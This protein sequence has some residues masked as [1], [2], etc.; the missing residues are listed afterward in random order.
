M[1]MYNLCQAKTENVREGLLGFIASGKSFLLIVKTV[2]KCIK[3]KKK[4]L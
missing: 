1:G 2:K 4:C 3:K